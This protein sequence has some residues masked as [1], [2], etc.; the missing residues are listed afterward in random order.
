LTTTV[1]APVTYEAFR[2][3]LTYR[4]VYAEIHGEVQDAYYSGLYRF[5]LKG[6]PKSSRR[7]VLGRW[8]QRKL[9]MY[10]AYLADFRAEA[11]A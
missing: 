5:E 9:E 2:T 6:S 3:G 4:D 1:T 11:A 10:E 8:R 7:A